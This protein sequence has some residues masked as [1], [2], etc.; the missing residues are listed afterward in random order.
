MGRR[1]GGRVPKRGKRRG[2]RGV[3][4]ESEDG[5]WEPTGCQEKGKST[6][7][8]YGGCDI[9]S[10]LHED[11]LLVDPDTDSVHRA[12]GNSDLACIVCT[13]WT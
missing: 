2:E 10:W 13:S 11:G 4:Y 7:H 12:R 1:V 3:W 8:E 6:V 5:D 9:M